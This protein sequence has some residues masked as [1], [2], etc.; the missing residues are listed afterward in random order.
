MKI[1]GC[2]TYINV[3]KGKLRPRARKC[4]FVSYG[5][6]VKGYRVWC[7]KSRRI[8]ISRDVKFDELSM[9]SCPLDIVVINNVGST[10]DS[11][12]E[13]ES[14]MASKAIQGFTMICI[15]EWNQHLIMCNGQ[16]GM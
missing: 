16:R 3:N 2:P 11:C 4:I 7:E 12:E 10:H 15:N 14:P 1:F 9:V 6:D 5:L 8:I 13:M